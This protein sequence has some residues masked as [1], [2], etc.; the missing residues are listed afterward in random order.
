MML[1]MPVLQGSHYHSFSHSS[2][3]S[4]TAW[5]IQTHIKTTASECLTAV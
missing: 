3:H 2:E 1:S 5:T 4:S